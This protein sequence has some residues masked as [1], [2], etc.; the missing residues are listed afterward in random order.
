MSKYN[1]KNL[2]E[3]K[4]FIDNSLSMNNINNKQIQKITQNYKY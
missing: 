4:T 3:L 1:L 2:N